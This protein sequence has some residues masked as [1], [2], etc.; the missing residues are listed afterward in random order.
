MPDAHRLV[1]GK[2]TAPTTIERRL[3]GVVVTA[4]RQLKLQLQ[5]D[6]AEEARALLKAKIKAMAKT[7]EA[8]GRSPAP[9]LLVRHMGKFAAALPENQFDVW[10]AYCAIGVRFMARSVRE[11]YGEGQAAGRLQVPLAAWRWAVGSG[12]VAPT[13]ADPG[14]GRGRWWRLP[15]QS[16]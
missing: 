12:L 14:C 10:D 5:E 11:Q 4:R 3:S 15:P 9:A 13:D 1:S 8:R 2:L 16:R 6:V 7:E